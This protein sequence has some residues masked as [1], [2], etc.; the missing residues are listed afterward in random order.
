MNRAPG[1]SDY[2]WLEHKLNCNGQ[3]IK[4]K[5]PE[6]YKSK[7]KDKSNLNSK[8]IKTDKTIVNWFTK[9]TP[10]KTKHSA[11]THSKAFTSTN[12]K[13][14]TE[15]LIQTGAKISDNKDSNN[16]T[17]SSH[18]QVKKNDQDLP[19]NVKKLGNGSNNVHGWGISGPSGKVEENTRYVITKN[20]KFSYSNTLGGSNSG[21]SNLLKKFLHMSNS[22]NHSSELTKKDLSLKLPSAAEKK[23][24]NKPGLNLNQSKNQTKK[25]TDNKYN[26][27]SIPLIDKFNN[28]SNEK[29]TSP[30]RTFF[31][32]LEKETVNTNSNKRLKLGDSS[33]IKCVSCPV[34]NK[35]LPS[36]NIN[37]HLDKC[38]L[39]N[40]KTHETSNVPSCSH[41]SDDSIIN[42]SSSS[43]S[44]LDNSVIESP[45]TQSCVNINKS[46][47]NMVNFEGQT[48][49]VCNTQ[50]APEISLNEHLDECMGAVFNDTVVIDDED[51]DNTSAAKNI[52]IESKYP[53][54]VCMQMISQRLMNEHLDI[55]LENKYFMH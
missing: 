22:K 19:L 18:I 17:N 54:P 8:N 13:A 31:T 48:C 38:L 4:I 34:C 2:W 14:L 44:N 11:F 1:P 30:I 46:K 33:D 42:I 26:I 5:E 41:T 28:S 37:Q 6:N 35:I 27:K 55:C 45:K 12:N 49:L 43:S 16:I 51:D 53:C 52:S 3:F 20:P 50:I 24:I 47:N 9:N 36:T 23:S 32:P 7:Q 10:T 40:N 39:E 21:Q 15:T 29:L 25:K